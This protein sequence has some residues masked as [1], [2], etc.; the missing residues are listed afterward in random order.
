MYFFVEFLD[1]S[2]VIFYTAFSM[3]RRSQ[4]KKINQ[5]PTKNGETRQKIRKN[6][7]E[8]ILIVYYLFISTVIGS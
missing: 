2:I 4:K 8:W 5:D 7:K 3:I 6:K 1:K